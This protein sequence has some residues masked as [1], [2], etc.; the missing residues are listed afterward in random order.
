MMGPE[1]KEEHQAVAG[2][3]RVV[4]KELKPQVNARMDG[5]KRTPEYKKLE[6]ERDDFRK[7]SGT[8]WKKV[9]E[10]DQAAYREF[11]EFSGS[12]GR[13]SYG[14]SQWS[15][16][17]ETNI[18]NHVLVAIKGLT[19]ISK[20]RHSDIER[21]VQKLIDNE[22][23]RNGYDKAQESHDRINGK[24]DAAGN[25]LSSLVFDARSE[26]R[27]VERILG[28]AQEH[29]YTA[30]KWDA[31]EARD[32]VGTDRDAERD[33]VKTE[34]F[35]AELEAELGVNDSAVSDGGK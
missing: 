5:I 6:K 18:H 32:E 23:R 22:K 31:R 26:V 16:G 29:E 8:A 19:K 11:I 28:F 34:K 17:I 7:L 9:E 21:M 27:K 15:S 25:K 1:S 12:W 3:L 4:Y 35:I 14:R 20:L 13:P 10:L 30:E 24:A 2:H 33:R